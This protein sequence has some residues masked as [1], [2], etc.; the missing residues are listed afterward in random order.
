MP[1]RAVSL[2]ATTAFEPRGRVKP[3][4]PAATDHPTRTQWRTVAAIP[5]FNEAV[6]IGSVVV[7]ALE[8]V[9]LVLVVDD[10]SSDGTAHIA[11]L[12]GAR[13]LRHPVN[14]GKGA[15]VRTAFEWARAMGVE[16]MV[17]LDGDM[18]HDPREIPK[19][20]APVLAGRAHLSLGF[21]FGEHTEMPGWRRVGKRVLDYATAAGAEGEVTDSQCGYRAFSRLA[22]EKLSFSQG[23]F[24]VESEVLIDAKAKGLAFAEV[25]IT[26]RYD[27]LDGSTQ[28][29]VAHAVGV[30]VSLFR[31]VTERQ[32]MVWLGVPALLASMLGL[33][34]G[35]WV[36]Y[37]LQATGE[38]AVGT[39]ILSSM[40]MLGGLFTGVSAVIFH[41][42]PRAVAAQLSP[43]R[44]AVDQGEAADATHPS[45]LAASAT[46]KTE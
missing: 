40:L 7:Q 22:I 8:H 18:Q 23:G 46:A 39:A 43:P 17:L 35:M 4:S 21:R 10:G 27:G 41:V 42:I 45:A 3:V 30:L 24:G 9:D 11:E 34:L 38:L 28:G 25:P 14:Q 19:V 6:T 13:V 37:T 2:M 20:L 1:D 32:P 15:A 5:A 16:A 29:P 26:C 44:M 12:A 33:T 31:I 36:L